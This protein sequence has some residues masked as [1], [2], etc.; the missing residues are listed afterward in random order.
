VEKLPGRTAVLAAALCLG[1]SYFLMIVGCTSAPPAQPDTR[2]ADEAAVRKADTDWA[3]AAQTKQVDAW[4]A[5]YTDDT[6]VLPPNDKV[7]GDK[8]SI[9]KAVGGL[10]ALPGLSIRW[11]PT[12]VE[13]AR[14]GDLAYSYGTYELSFND[15][16]G[17][18]M[19]DHGKYTEVWKKQSDGGWKCVLD[20]WSS[21][22][23]ASS[24]PSR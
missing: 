18:P 21:D 8:D 12:K 19:S 10:L 23:P 16:G 9:R 2:A 5:F 4:V 1:L 15:P 11:Q 13:V 7:A 6:V 3:A 14:S 22:L 24:P 20:M 17:K